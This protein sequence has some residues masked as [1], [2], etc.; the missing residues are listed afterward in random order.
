MPIASINDI[1]IYYEVHGSGPSLFLIGGFSLS[2]HG[3]QEFLAPFS[4]HFQ[5]VVFDNRGVG[6]SSSPPTDYTTLQMA[7]DTSS[8][9][10]HL[11]VESAHLMGV[12]MGT[13]IAEQL[14]LNHPQKVQ[15]VVLC[16]PFARLPKL[17]A[18]L[19]KVEA[20]LLK[21][22]LDRGDLLEMM[23]PWLLSTSTVETP[24]GVEQFLEAMLSVPY[25]QTLDGFVGQM[26]ALINCDL[27]KE[28]HKI[29]HQM[30]LLVGENDLL[31]PLS[32][33]EEI[34]REAPDAKIH[35]FENR[36]HVFQAEIPEEVAEQTLS[37]L[38]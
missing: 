15:K 27:R 20:K 28:V 30:L 31:T 29:H 33:A 1:D 32:C 19:V 10:D 4:K 8:L 18:H 22:G 36:G 38:L 5:V 23:V 2:H 6:Q 11:G 34:C 37:F 21:K 24:G 9:M 7:Q 16:A 14:C 3:F 13:L 26:H 25:P 35:L 12:S 17:S